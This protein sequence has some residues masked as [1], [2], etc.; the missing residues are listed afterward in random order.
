MKTIS[1]LRKDGLV[2]LARAFLRNLMHETHPEFELVFQFP[3]SGADVLN[4]INISRERER[5]RLISSFC[6]YVCDI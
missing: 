4:A 1:V 3:F 6:L 5:E 2:H